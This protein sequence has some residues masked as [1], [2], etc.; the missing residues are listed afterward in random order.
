MAALYNQVCY[1]RSAL[2]CLSGSLQLLEIILL[3]THNIQLNLCKTATLKK[4]LF[5]KTIYH[6]M[7]VKSMAECCEGSI[8]RYFPLSLSYH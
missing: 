4:K 8:L 6:L 7:K 1:K 5:F 2:Y 3:L